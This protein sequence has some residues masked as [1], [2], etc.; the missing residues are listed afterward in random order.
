M[1]FMKWSRRR[2]SR[3]LGQVDGEA[4]EK[5]IFGQKKSL[6][7][8]LTRPAEPLQPLVVV[9]PEAPQRTKQALQQLADRVNA[10]ARTGRLRFAGAKEWELAY[11]P[12]NMA[13]HP[14]GTPEEL[15]LWDAL[16]RINA[17]LK[18]GGL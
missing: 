1:S 3:T 17:R 5:V 10:L 18:A 8:M 9:D 2:N 14:L 13:D 4:V 6:A 16:D 15:E 12:G 7:W 11:R